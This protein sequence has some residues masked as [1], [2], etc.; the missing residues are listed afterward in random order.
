[1]TA[2]DVVVLGAGSA[3]SWVADEAVAAGRSVAVVEQL[4]VGGNCP[5]VACI[6]S[7]AMLASAHARQ[8]A[9]DLARLGG[10]AAPSLGPDAA[11]FGQAVGAAMS[12]P[13]TGTTPARPVS[14][15]NP[16]SR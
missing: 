4:R 1:M 11:A 14:S 8:Q 5:Y 6:P 3:G 16:A 12:C 13:T 7:K 10:D 2:F 9:R 15:P